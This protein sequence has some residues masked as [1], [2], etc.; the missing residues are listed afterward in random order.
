MQKFT[1]PEKPIRASYAIFKANKMKLAV[2]TVV[3]VLSWGVLAFIDESLPDK[4][5]L[6]HF[7]AILCSVIVGFLVEAGLIKITL[8]YVDGR[9]GTV[10]ELFAYP[11]LAVKIFCVQF[12]VVAAILMALMVAIIAGAVFVGVA[13]LFLS[14]SADGAL[15]V[16]T[17]LAETVAFIAAT[18]FIQTR[19]RFAPYFI[20]DKNSGILES[21]KL[22]W[23]TTRGHVIKLIWIQFLLGSL[24]IL[25][26][27]A[28]LV[29]LFVTLPITLLAG[30]YIFRKFEQQLSQPSLP[31]LTN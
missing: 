21:Y 16:V 2:L 15:F 6:P 20:A 13:S 5:E 14:D 10:A 9:S 29:G 26:V 8:A 19:L 7:L 28:L 3:F 27:L 12:L 17:L 23:N 18:I 11:K 24:N 25:G 30:A 31:S 1:F 22:S 4:P